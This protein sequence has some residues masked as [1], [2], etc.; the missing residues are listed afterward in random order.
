L[1][2]HNRELFKNYELRYGEALYTIGLYRQAIPY[3]Q[4]ALNKAEY[5]EYLLMEKIARS[6]QA[7]G[8]LSQAEK[9]YNESIEKQE[10]N[11]WVHLSLA[12]VYFKQGKYREAKKHY[13][14]LTAYWDDKR[15]QTDKAE[16]ML[17]EVLPALVKG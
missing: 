8:D 12:E 10:M 14:F 9:Y 7:V 13:K 17:R 11:P 1:L 6:Y 5:N 2:E 4:A 3:L 15:L 16:Y